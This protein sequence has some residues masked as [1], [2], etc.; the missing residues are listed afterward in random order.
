VISGCMRV[1]RE[2]MRLAL[3]FL[4]NIA[5]AL[6]AMNQGARAADLVSPAEP[7]APIEIVNDWKFQLTLYGW[8][9]SLDGE[10]GVRGLDPVDVDVSFKEILENLDGAVM[11]SFYATNGRFV[12]LTD[13]VWAK[14]SDEVDVGPFGGTVS[15]EQRQLIASAVGGYVLPLDVPGLQLS[16]VAG[17]RY[18]RLKAEVEFN[19]ALLPVTF[20]EE[21]TKNW[22]DPIV[23]ALAHYDFDENWFV[24]LYADVGGFGVGSDLTAQGFASIGYRWSDTI[25]T[26][27]GYRV[28]YTDYDKD[29]FVYNMTQHGPYMGL[30]IHF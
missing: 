1:R 14:I 29:G 23:G 21:G 4:S 27:V 20:E 2:G 6:L 11:G 19:P 3:G 28:L 18:N 22:V 13:L 7:P 24:N 30:G 10:V 25:S 17:I 26:A 16:P 12:V 9:T 5:L 15:F 8:A